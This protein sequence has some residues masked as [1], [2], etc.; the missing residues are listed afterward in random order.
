MEEDD[1]KGYHSARK[2]HL[3]VDI[4]TGVTQVGHTHWISYNFAGRLGAAETPPQCAGRH[5]PLLGGR[6]QGRDALHL[7]GLEDACFLAEK[8][9]KAPELEDHESQLGPGCSKPGF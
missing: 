8:D 1:G 9:N 2:G 5:V 4:Y 7:H 6:T 3:D